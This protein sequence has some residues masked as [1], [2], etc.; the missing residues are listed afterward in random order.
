MDVHP[1]MVC[2]DTIMVTIL[3]LVCPRVPLFLSQ[4]IPRPAFGPAAKIHTFWYK[5]SLKSL[6][7]TEIVTGRPQ[8]PVS[9][10]PGPRESSGPWSRICSHVR[11]V[12]SSAARP[13][14]PTGIDYL[15][16]WGWKLQRTKGHEI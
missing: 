11:E 10:P 5:S 6:Q 2:F 7:V 3:S 16:V 13:G 4:G 14:E 8:A 9:P 12:N 15:G 1:P